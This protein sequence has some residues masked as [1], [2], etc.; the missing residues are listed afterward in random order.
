MLAGLI[1]LA[2]LPQPSPFTD[3]NA[4]ALFDAANGLVN[5]EGH[6]CN[7]NTRAA[8]NQGRTCAAVGGT[9]KFRW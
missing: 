6:A 2:R 3:L 4:L 9:T 1:P 8:L 5:S 7:G